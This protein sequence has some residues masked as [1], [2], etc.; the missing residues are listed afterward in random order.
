[1]IRGDG[2]TPLQIFTHLGVTANPDGAW[3]VQQQSPQGQMV[4]SW[5]A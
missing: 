1:M 2:S 4:L 3:T 5:R